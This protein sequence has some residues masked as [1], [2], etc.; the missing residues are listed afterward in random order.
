MAKLSNRQI[1]KG[2]NS[3]FLRKWQQNTNEGLILLHDLGKG[4][5]GF[6]LLPEN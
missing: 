2:D 5:Q 3:L 4:N 6:W 1:S